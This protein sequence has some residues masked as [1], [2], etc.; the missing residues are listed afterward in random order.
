VRRILNV[1]GL[2]AILVGLVSL[3]GVA[4]DLLIHG[5]LLE[6]GSSAPGSLFIITGLHVL[7]RR[8]HRPRPN[9]EL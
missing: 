4:N 1:V 9:E 7:A 5:R 2:L 8:S 3:V 6:F